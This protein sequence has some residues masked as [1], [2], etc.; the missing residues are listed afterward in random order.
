MNSSGDTTSYVSR[1]FQLD[2]MFSSASLGSKGVEQTRQRV[3]TFL[4]W[5]VFL[6]ACLVA[7]VSWES[8]AHPTT[9]VF[10][11]VAILFNPLVPVYLAR[12]T[13]APID[14]VC[15]ILF[16]LALFLTNKRTAQS[17]D[18]TPGF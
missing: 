13:W 6:S 12:S 3:Y 11:V 15:A 10:A 14:V 2:G 18:H 8:D 7:W 4:R 17:V 1:A 9:F 5:V 16:A